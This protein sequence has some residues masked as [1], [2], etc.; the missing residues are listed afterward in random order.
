MKKQPLI[1]IVGPTAS[2]KTGLSIELAK[3]YGGEVISADSRQVYRGLDIGTEK[4]TKEEMQ[5]IPHHCIDIASPRRTF[6]VEQWRKHAEKAIGTITKHGTVPIIAGGTAFYV[7][8]LVYGQQFPR[9]APNAKLR[10]KLASK[11]PEELLEILQRLDS[12][13]ASTVEQKNPRRLIRAIEIAT[14]LGRV[15]KVHKKSTH[16]DVRWIGINP[17]IDILT[18]RITARFNTTLQNG[19]I[20]EIK[21]LREDVGLSWKRINELGLE[22][23]IVGEYIRGEIDKN[24][25]KEKNIRELRKYAKRQ[26]TWLKRNKEI[27]WYKNKEEALKSF[28]NL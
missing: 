16:Y 25:M 17:G 9:V 14:E 1:V 8:T 2:G 11:S 12:E 3:K 21:K 28:S 7:D 18:E 23:R 5:G 22:Y 27:H 20:E 19:L 15:P 6:T 10:K 26:M 13:R 4:V 24:E